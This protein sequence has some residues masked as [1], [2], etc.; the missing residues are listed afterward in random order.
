MFDLMMVSLGIDSVEEILFLAVGALFT[1]G[2]VIALT[3]INRWLRAKANITVFKNEEQLREYLV[4]VIFNGFYAVV[5]SNDFSKVKEER[6]STNAA[7]KEY[8]KQTSPEVLKKLKVNTKNGALDKVI[9]S[10]VN[11]II[12]NQNIL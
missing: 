10:E 2:L 5:K 11:K 9:D 3:F 1:G 8:V 4:K 12:H 6:G 7:I